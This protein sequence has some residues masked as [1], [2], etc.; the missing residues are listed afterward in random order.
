MEETIVYI[1]KK[2]I[3]QTIGKDY[4]YKE[5]LQDLKDQGLLNSFEDAVELRFDK[6][7]ALHIQ[8]VLE[9]YDTKDTPTIP[10]KGKKEKE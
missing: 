3:L 7:K 5:I 10:T 4:N 9:F 6:S 8:S 1:S 2:K